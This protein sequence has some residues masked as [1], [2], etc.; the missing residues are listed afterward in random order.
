[1][2]SNVGELFYTL[3]VLDDEQVLRVLAYIMAETLA[4]HAPVVETLGAFLN[5]DMQDWW[6]PDAA[7]FDLLRDK[8][9]INAMLSEVAGDVTANAHVA[10]TVKVQKKIIADCL[11]GD[12]RTK[13]ENWLPRYMRFPAATYLGS[14]IDTSVTDGGDSTEDIANAA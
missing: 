12:G 8:S 14:T 4:A 3:T 10:S 13:V 2:S 1:M 9:A 6:K 5:I 11:A 7:F